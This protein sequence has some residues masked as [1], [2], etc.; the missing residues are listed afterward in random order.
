MTD[1]NKRLVDYQSQLEKL[2]VSKSEDLK[3][4][5][6]KQQLLTNQLETFERE[7]EDLKQRYQNEIE[8]YSEL[9]SNKEKQVS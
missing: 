1:L 4:F 2:N 7:N 8:K 9:L 3:A 6:E 5:V